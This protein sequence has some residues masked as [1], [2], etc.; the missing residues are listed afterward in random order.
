MEKVYG[1]EARHDALIVF[2]STNR[3]VLIYGYGEE[4]GQG[5]DYRQSFEH[6]PTKDEL[7]QVLQQH[8]NALTDLKILTGYV[9]QG[10]NVYLSTENEFNFKAAFDLA[11]QTSGAT[12]PIKFKLGEDEHGTPVYHTFTDMESFTDFYVNAIAFVNAMLNEG[13]QLKDA[14]KEWVKSLTINVQGV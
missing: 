3:A 11:V 6:V 1:A 8:I 14:A 13:W 4:D 10:K 2:D 12:L 5:Y 9:W 7:V